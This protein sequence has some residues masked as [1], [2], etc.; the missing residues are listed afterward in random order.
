MIEIE[1]LKKSFGEIQALKEIHMQIREGELFG[2]VGTNG[3]GKSTLLR[4]LAGV[5]R[6]DQGKVRIDGQE[7]YENER[8]KSRICFLPDDFWYPPN[9]APA[10]MA[11]LYRKI[12]EK[13]DRGRFEEL[14]GRF[15]LDWKRKIRTFSKGMQKQ[16]A[17]F[18]GI[19]ANTDYLLCDETFDGLDPLVRQEVKSMLA[20]ELLNREFT[21]VVAS[22]NLRE[23]EDICDHVG[24]LHRGGMLLSENL[25]EMK[26]HTQ[27]V[28][29]VI[30]NREREAELLRELTLV[31]WEKRG[32]MLL[33]VAKG[34]RQEIM[35]RVKSKNP[36]FSEV[37]P[38]SLEEIFIS[39]TEVSGYDGK[40][41]RR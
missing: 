1:G 7:V 27:K 29:C 5:L 32:S 4:I 37:L 6:Q 2:V 36:V 34:T 40:A 33:L 8:I 22:H 31:R 26:F 14:C 12:Y 17:I 13:F 3:A 20:V 23:L 15:G 41:Y 21:P 28:Q 19:C 35:D 10:D 18:L 9:A 38:L 39:E 30:G 11:V 25:E 24:L 16:A